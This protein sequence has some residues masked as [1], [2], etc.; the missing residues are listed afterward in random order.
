MKPFCP[1]L[2]LFWQNKIFNNK[3]CVIVPAGQEA[4]YGIVTI[5]GEE[6]NVIE[7]PTKGIATGSMY[8]CVDSGTPY[9]FIQQFDA[10]GR[11]TEGIWK[12]L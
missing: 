7:A 8:I 3:K 5:Y 9:M 11:E 2:K 6:I 10:E 12:I 4:K 1:P